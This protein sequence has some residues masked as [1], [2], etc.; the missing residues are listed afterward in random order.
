MMRQHH[1]NSNLHVRRDEE[2]ENSSQP[3]LDIA[4]PPKRRLRAPLWKR[5][6]G[7]CFVLGFFGIIEL[8]AAALT[9]SYFDVTGVRL[10]GLSTTPDAPVQQ[11]SQKLIGQNWL[12]ADRA[13]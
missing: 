3:D 6:R 8:G 9:A 13:P 7:L 10:E 2:S 1:N 5:L 4:P 11:L 12:R